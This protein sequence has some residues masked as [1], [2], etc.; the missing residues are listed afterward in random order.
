MSVTYDFAPR[1][2]CRVQPPQTH[3]GRVLQSEADSVQ[4]G[5]VTCSTLCSSKSLLCLGTSLGMLLVAPLQERDRAK[6][7]VVGTHPGRVTSVAFYTNHHTR[8]LL[9]GGV[10]GTIK[11]WALQEHV[12]AGTG[13][14]VQTLHGHDSA[15]TCLVSV[16]G[17]LLSG[18][19]WVAHEHI[20]Y[21][22]SSQ[23]G[24]MCTM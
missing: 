10:D 2:L 9:S 22:G 13:T 15:I 11:C 6:L 1:L 5:E 20:T 18:A 23:C 16:E 12:S 14:C 24:T 17:A 7:S 21:P 3:T 8:Y 4:F 19:R